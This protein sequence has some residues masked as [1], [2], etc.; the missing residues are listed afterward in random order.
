MDNTCQ[1]SANGHTPISSVDAA[2]KEA[3]LGGMTE[4]AD[5]TGPDVR[6]EA[7]MNSYNE[8]TNEILYLESATLTELF[9]FY[10][11]FIREIRI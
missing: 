11:E 3:R 8:S 4:S 10:L 2:L 5:R 1:G 7:L 9:F 6:H